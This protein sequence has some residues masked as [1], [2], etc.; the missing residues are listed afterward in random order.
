MH[1]V[2][3]LH[4]SRRSHVG[5]ADEPTHGHPQGQV[6]PLNEAGR[7]M[8]LAAG[9]RN[10]LEGSD[11]GQAVVIRRWAILKGLTRINAHGSVGQ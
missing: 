8:V 3:R 9:D 2:L 5:R 10:M 11:R 1:D 6:L 4:S 7:D